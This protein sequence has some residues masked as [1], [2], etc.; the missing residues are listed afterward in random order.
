MSEEV[1]Y[2]Q[3][4]T[5]TSDSKSGLLVKLMQLCYFR[6]M[7]QRVHIPSATSH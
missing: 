3:D 1:A 7:L 2:L 6:A 4:L 5:V